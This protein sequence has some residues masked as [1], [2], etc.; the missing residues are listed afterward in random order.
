MNEH[1]S[2]SKRE[3]ME[4]ARCPSVRGFKSHPPHHKYT[5]ELSAF[6]ACPVSYQVGYN[7]HSWFL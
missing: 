2:D 6:T 4:T 1:D 5:P 3:G 7:Q